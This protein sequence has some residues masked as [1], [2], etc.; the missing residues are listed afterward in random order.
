M[1][2]L[3]VSSATPIDRRFVSAGPGRSRITAS[4]R[5][6]QVPD[7]FSDNPPRF[8]AHAYGTC[9]PCLGP[10][11][12]HDCGIACLSSTE[13]L[14]RITRRKWSISVERRVTGGVYVLLRPCITGRRSLLRATGERIHAKSLTI[15]AAATI[16]ISISRSSPSCPR[17]FSP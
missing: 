1:L 15:S 2:F 16:G 8:C 14:Q 3:S 13:M 7:K 10:P 11:N 17:P 4:T 5:F 6:C 12:F 9:V